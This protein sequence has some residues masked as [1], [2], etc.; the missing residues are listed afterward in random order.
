MRRR[1][2]IRVLGSA[3]AIP[4]LRPLAARA[5]QPMP[6]IG[7]LGAT[8]P[9]STPPLMAA[10][11][12]G[13]KAQGFVE[14]QNVAIEYR[15]ARGDYGRL[16]G[17]AAELVARQ[18]SVIFATGGNASAPAAKTATA[19]IPIVFTTGSDPVRQGVVESLNRP[20][21]NVTGVTFIARELTA[22]RMEF[23][24]E[25][26][27]TTSTVAVL[28]N[29][30]NVNTAM[31]M[32][33]IGNAARA[34]GLQVHY[35]RAS[36]D[37]ELDDTFANLVPSRAQA[38]FVNT[39]ASLVSRRGHIIALAARHALPA[40]YPRTE[41]VAAGGLISYATRVADTYHQAGVYVGRVLKGE[42]PADLPIQQPTTFDFAI[43]RKT[44][45]ALGITFPP[46]FELR[47]TEVIE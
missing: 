5:Q 31:D 17:L 7:I 28:I 47:A 32:D 37:A 40:V 39:D 1:A 33:D 16:P 4:I 42:K 22:K 45:A 10:F 30:A 44:A 6:V 29:P 36:T 15:W 14:H 26:A 34:L 9:D 8:S 27:P 13:L 11:L 21:R 20:G 3:A 38:L 2:F 46:S 12:Q 18:V 23:L 24:H 35:L 41:Y 43:N 19:T 25:L